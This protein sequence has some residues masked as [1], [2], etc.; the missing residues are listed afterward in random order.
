VLLLALVLVA[1]ATDL[2]WHKVYNWTTYPGIVAAIGLSGAR[3]LLEATAV[4]EGA[5]LDWLTRLPVDDCLIGLVVCGL[6]MLVCY[7]VFPGIGGGDVKLVAMLGAFLGPYQGIEAV[8]WTFVFGG[9]VG[10]IV[11]I[12]RV[13]P[14]KLAAGVLRQS[15]WTLRLGHWGPLSPEEHAQLQPPLFLGPSALAA[16]VIVQF[17]LAD[18]V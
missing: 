16:V 7:V 8:L 4:V 15:L 14:M 2:A 5:Q 1:T 17:G 13:G 6:L 12:W 11:L 10:L 9:C 18:L 3:S